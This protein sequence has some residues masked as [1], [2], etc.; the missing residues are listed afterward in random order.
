MCVQQTVILWREA[1]LG[2]GLS[3]MLARN[4]AAHH[5]LETISNVLHEQTAG[6]RYVNLLRKNPNM[7][8]D[9]V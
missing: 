4:R 9:E 7:R 3:L 1:V 6:N 2:P 8:N 5:F